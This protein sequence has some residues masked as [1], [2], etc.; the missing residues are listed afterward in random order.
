M[1][2]RGAIDLDNAYTTAANYTGHWDEP[3]VQKGFVLDRLLDLDD[4]SELSF[5]KLAALDTGDGHLKHLSEAL[6]GNLDAKGQ[7]FFEKAVELD[8]NSEAFKK[9]LEHFQS[10]NQAVAQR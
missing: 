5:K 6:N 2:K 4:S 3:L 9:G 8:P 7:A 10:D 1:N